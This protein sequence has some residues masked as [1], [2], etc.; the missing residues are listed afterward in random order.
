MDYVGVLNVGRAY[1]AGLEAGG[2]TLDGAKPSS[3]MAGANP[4]ANCS[5]RGKKKAMSRENTKAKTTMFSTVVLNGR[6]PPTISTST[7]RTTWYGKMER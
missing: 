6:I 4:L 7:H 1:C 5:V 3:Y 2:L